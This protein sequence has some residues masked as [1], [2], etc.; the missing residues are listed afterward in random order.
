MF[1]NIIELFFSLEKETAQRSEDSR[2]WSGQRW[3]DNYT[4]SNFRGDRAEPSTYKR[5][6]CQSYQERLSKV[7]LLGCGWTE[8]VKINMGKLL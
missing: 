1:Y 7:H 3:K 5:I 8:G 6:Q 4:K 2:S